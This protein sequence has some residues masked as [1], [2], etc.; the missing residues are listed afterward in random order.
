MDSTYGG[1]NIWY[2]S[3]NIY[4]SLWVC[5]C[6]VLVHVVWYCGLWGIAAGKCL[7]TGRHFYMFKTVF[8]IH[9][10]VYSPVRIDYKST[11]W[12]MVNW[13]RKI[14]VYSYNWSHKI[15]CDILVLMFSYWPLLN[16]S[17]EAACMSG[18]NHH[19]GI[20]SARR[21]YSCAKGLGKN[22][23]KWT[24]EESNHPQMY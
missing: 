8:V 22:R 23:R 4:T 13:I 1:F 9:L 21:K 12:C 7:P 17:R 10:F 18:W 15:N 14:L 24:V 3:S 16:T 6:V 19:P 11:C 5:T 2:L 20:E